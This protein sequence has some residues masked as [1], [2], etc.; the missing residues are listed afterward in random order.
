MSADGLCPHDGDPH[1]CPPCQRARQPKPE[2]L[3]PE[4][5]VFVARYDGDCPGCHLPIHVGQFCARWSDGRTRHMGCA[6]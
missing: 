4:T 2:P 5:P 6:P 1:T 3:T